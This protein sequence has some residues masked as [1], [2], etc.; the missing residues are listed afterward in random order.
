MKNQIKEAVDGCKPNTILGHAVPPL[1]VASI[2][3]EEFKEGPLVPHLHFDEV[4]R[5]T[6]I[7]HR[8]AFIFIRESDLEFY[9]E[10]CKY[11]I[12]T[13]YFHL[14]VL[15]DEAVQGKRIGVIRTLIM[16]FSEHFNA[17]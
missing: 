6:S 15:D 16:L 2:V 10:K 4:L 11:E 14:V 3:R 8:V 13:G 17:T 1:M 12:Q 5:D 9:Q 7:K